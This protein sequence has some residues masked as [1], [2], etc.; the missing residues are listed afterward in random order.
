MASLLR[1][2]IWLPCLLALLVVGTTDSQAQDSR[3]LIVH[4]SDPPASDAFVIQL[5]DYVTSGASWTETGFSING[6]VI[7]ITHRCDVSNLPT[8][9]YFDDEKPLTGMLLDDYEVRWTVDY[10][11]FGQTTSRTL[12]LQ[13]PMPVT[14]PIGVPIPAL[15]LFGW[16]ALLVLLAGVYGFYR[17][18][19]P[20]PSP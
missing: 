2:G 9:S 7:E 18:T 16:L 3:Q 11:Y 5:H 13:V 15:G 8:I 14:E 12:T 20:A 4:P 17:K 6:N 19:R 10:V 1:P